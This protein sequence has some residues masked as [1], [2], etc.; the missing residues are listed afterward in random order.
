MSDKLTVSYNGA[1][2]TLYA[3][4]RRVSDGYVWNGSAV[5]AWVNAN[6]ATYKIALADQGG[7]LYSVSVPADLP[8]GI[9]YDAIYYKQVGGSPAITDDILTREQFT[10]RGNIDS[11]DLG[12]GGEIISQDDISDFLGTL[13]LAIE[14]QQDPDATTTDDAH[15]QRAIVKAEA[16][17]KAVL[18]NNF[19]IPL[20]VSGVLVRS[21]S[22]SVALPLV[23]VAAV[24]YASFWLNKWRQVQ[25][26]GET[27]M[28]QAAISALGAA[29]E[30]DA[31]EQ[32][33]AMVRWADGYSDGLAVD[34]DM[35]D[36]AARLAGTS[37][38]AAPMVYGP[39]TCCSPW[40]PPV[41]PLW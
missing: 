6:I 18:G 28:S 36:G 38:I 30:S 29:W 14:S 10:W 39:Q 2:A 40:V 24:E 31:D 23:K 4:L 32:L 3:I 33:R 26:L 12:D 17:V 1:G 37:G 35:L 11:E 9:D 15:V 16:R 22:S 13:N 25:S 27:R 41:Y 19:K 7:D 34:L 21:A 5:V 20:A 8:R